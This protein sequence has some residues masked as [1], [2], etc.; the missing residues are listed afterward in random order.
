MSSLLLCQMQ[1]GQGDQFVRERECILQTHIYIYIVHTYV[2]FGCIDALFGLI[3][4]FGLLRY[5]NISF[6]LCL[7]ASS[8]TNPTH[9][10]STYS[11]L[12]ESL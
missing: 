6:F 5:V 10:W 9:G 7:L 4:H 2:Y 8:K 12:S 1:F 3:G 11:I